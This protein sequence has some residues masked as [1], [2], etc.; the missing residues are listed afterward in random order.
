V[1]P[2]ILV[3]KF[4]SEIYPFSEEEI[5]TYR[6]KIDFQYLSKNVNIKWSFELVK[7]F[8]KMWDWE[9]LDQNRAVFKRL[10]IG[11]LFPGRVNLFPCDCFF[12]MNFCEREN[13]H[14]N[15]KKFLDAS[16]L[17]DDFPEIFIRMR[18]ALESGAVDAAMIKSYYN[19]ENPE[20]VISL[21]LELFGLRNVNG[22]N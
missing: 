19:S 1:V 7:R 5:S 15:F 12:Q 11:L 4:I 2:N 8:E 14:H 20:E 21:N 10:T 9:S 3:N 18:M 22:N 16:S 17:N 6:E 13:C